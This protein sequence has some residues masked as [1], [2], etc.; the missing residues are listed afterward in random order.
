MKKITRIALGM[1]AALAVAMLA[2]QVVKAEGMPCTEATLKGFLEYQATCE[3]ELATVK[4]AKAQADA[5]VAAL[6]AAGVSGLELQIATDKAFNAGNLVQMYEHKLN[7]A[8]ANVAFGTG[9]GKVSQYHLDMEAKWAGRMEV[10][11]TQTKLDAANQLTAAAKEQLNILQT[12]LVNQKANAAANPALAANVTAME[13]Q[14]AQAEATYAQRKA[15]SDALAAQVAQEKA[16]L[17][18]A[19]NADNDQYAAFVKNYPA[20]EWGIRWFE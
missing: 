17:N 12:A 18:W 5:D 11:G 1:I 16:T 9:R 3:Q 10:D 20:G 15:E 13:A 8:K 7:G 2:P 14:V 4:Q 6:K 19:T